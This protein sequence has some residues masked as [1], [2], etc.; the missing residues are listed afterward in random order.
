MA[1]NNLISDT[2][3]KSIYKD[4]KI[5]I[6]NSVASTCEDDDTKKS[7]VDMIDKDG[8]TILQRAIERTYFRDKE[9]YSNKM[10]TGKVVKHEYF[11]LKDESQGKKIASKIHVKE[12]ETYSRNTFKEIQ[13]DA[14]WDGL[15]VWKKMYFK[16]ASVKDESIIKIAI[17]MYLK[18]VKNMS[19][20]EIE[21]VIKNKPF[22]INLSYLKDDS[23]DFRHWINDKMHKVF[24]AKM[25]KEV[26]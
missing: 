26:A 22:S 10:Q 25:Y 7:L 20:E 17:Q 9:L 23:I 21:K 4:D 6:T 13:L 5:I 14:A 3:I 24:L 19:I 1:C 2:D 12:L 15:V 11:I 16:F 8:H 18:Q